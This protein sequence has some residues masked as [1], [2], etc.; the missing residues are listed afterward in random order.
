MAEKKASVLLIE[1]NSGH[2]HALSKLMH[3]LVNSD[4]NL[5]T[6]DVLS[7]GLSR[8]ESGNIDLVLLDLPIGNEK[9]LEAVRSIKEQSL[10]VPVFVIDSSNNEK[11]GPKAR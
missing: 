6:T 11:L 3:S 2:P 9:G 5:E 7:N 1:E 4:F 10:T 8:L